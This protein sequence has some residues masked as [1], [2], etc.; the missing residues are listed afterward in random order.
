[1]RTAIIERQMKNGDKIKLSII[2]DSDKKIND[3]EELEIICTVIKDM[4]DRALKNLF[5]DDSEDII[6]SMMNEEN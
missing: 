6:K 4:Y 1:M 2:M 5:Q 3:L